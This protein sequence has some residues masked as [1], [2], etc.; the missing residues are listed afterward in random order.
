[1]QWKIVLRRR[2]NNFPGIL[3]PNNIIFRGLKTW[4]R[5]AAFFLGEGLKK[6]EKKIQK[7]N[8]VNL[9]KMN[10]NICHRHIKSGVIRDPR[11]ISYMMSEKNRK[12]KTLFIIFLKY[13]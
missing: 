11:T 2:P 10:N 9:L 1:M 13:I 5:R 4:L 6:F 8:G 7:K 12:K 3:Y